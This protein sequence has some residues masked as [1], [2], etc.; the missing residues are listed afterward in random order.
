MNGNLT[1]IQLVLAVSIPTSV[2][3]IG[4]LFNVV[5]N[6]RLSDRIDRMNDNF[7]NQV[8]TLLSTIHGVDVRVV[9]LEERS[10]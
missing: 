7:N 9:E 1:L 8:T 10:K 6:N 2:A 3:M 5:A 4:L